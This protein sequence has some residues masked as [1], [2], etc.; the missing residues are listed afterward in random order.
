MYRRAPDA[1]EIGG[2]SSDFLESLFGS[3]IRCASTFEGHGD[4]APEW[5]QDLREDPG[6]QDGGRTMSLLAAIAYVLKRALSI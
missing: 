5:V 6:A 2:G 3:A 1:Q 4:P